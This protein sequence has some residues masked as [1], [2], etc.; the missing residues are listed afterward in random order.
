MLALTSR[1]EPRTLRP[2]Q[3]GL[4]T[5]L[6]PLQ[7]GDSGVKF[8]RTNMQIDNLIFRVSNSSISNFRV[9]QG[10]CKPMILSPLISAFAAL[11]KDLSPLY[12]RLP[13]R[14]FTCKIVADMCWAAR[15]PVPANHESLLAA[16]I[17]EYRHTFPFLQIF[18]G[19]SSVG[20]ALRSQCRGREFDSPPLHFF[21]AVWRPFKLLSY[22]V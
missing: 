16:Q 19:G 22:S 5:V 18:W 13:L 6:L 9:R 4:S 1:P 21:P 2:K 20:R 14:I 12:C 15:Y 7:C 3:N 17:P 10:A 11:R 8:F